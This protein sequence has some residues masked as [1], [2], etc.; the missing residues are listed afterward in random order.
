MNERKV[1][2]R[3]SRADSIKQ[4]KE[5]VSLK[6]GSFEIMQ[7]QEQKERK[8]KRHEESLCE[9]WGTMRQVIFALWDPKKKGQKAYSEI[10]KSRER[11]TH[12]GL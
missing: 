1:Q 4:K 10:P 9:F 12:L 6:T 7:S 2:Q 8:I 3:A 11:Y 5:L